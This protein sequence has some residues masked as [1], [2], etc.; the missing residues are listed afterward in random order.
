MRDLVILLAGYLVAIPVGACLGYAIYA[1][2]C[3]VTSWL[4]R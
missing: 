2:E 3:A 1:L 4:K